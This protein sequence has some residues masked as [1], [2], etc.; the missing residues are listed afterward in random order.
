MT[1]S[2]DRKYVLELRLEYSGGYIRPQLLK[3]WLV[4]KLHL[5]RLE[6]GEVSVLSVQTIAEEGISTKAR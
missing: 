3:E 5:L 1:P 4:E 6:S 2:L